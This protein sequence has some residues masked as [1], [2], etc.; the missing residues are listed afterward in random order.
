MNRRISL[1]I[2]V[3]CIGL[4]LV[5]W[6][7]D[8]VTLQ[9]EWTVYTV[10]CDGGP[11]RDNVCTGTVVHS[12][13]YRFRALRAHSEVLFW[14]AGEKGRSGRYTDCTIQDGRDWSCTANADAALTIT[15]RMVR[16]R[17]VPDS[18]VPTIP[19]HQVQKWKWELLRLGIPVGHSAMD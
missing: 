18:G 12:K 2:L 13:R 4:A 6:A 5:V 7:T 1:F 11:W 14:T 8:F 9:G 16:G 17:P 10:A 3:L 15:H 19:Y